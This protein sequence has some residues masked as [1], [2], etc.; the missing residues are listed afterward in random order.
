MS[1]K[2]NLK[3]EGQGQGVSKPETDPSINDNDTANTS[4]ER[5]TD[6]KAGDISLEE[7]VETQGITI[8]L[9][10]RALSNLYEVIRELCS[11]TGN[12]R[13]L[14]KHKIPTYVIPQK[15]I[16]NGH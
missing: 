11:Y 16:K 7:I 10:S 14:L 15:V 6:S 4:P 8:Q 3:S 9:Q 13:I 2:A 12:N 5:E 1:K